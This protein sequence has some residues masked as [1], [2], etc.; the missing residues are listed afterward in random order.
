MTRTVKMKLISIG[1]AASIALIGLAL[2]T[3]TR[4]ANITNVTLPFAFAAFVP[5]ANGGLGEVVNLSGDDHIVV[6]V[7]IDNGGNF[8]VKQHFNAH[9]SGVG[10]TT[11]AKYQFNEVA[12]FEETLNPPGG[13]ENLTLTFK[14]TGQGP[15]NNLV[16]RETFHIT[17]NANGDVTVN[18]SSF[19]VDCT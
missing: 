2:P 6:S 5:C 4:A 19:S 8:H 11:G 10:S 16:I 7:T 14:V 3:P 13:E 18:R 15:G 9:G 17:V 12:N 1:L